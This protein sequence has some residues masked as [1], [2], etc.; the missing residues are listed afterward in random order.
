MTKH[1]KQRLSERFLLDIT[2]QEL[3]VIRRLLRSGYYILIE[4]EDANKIKVLT[5]YKGRY[6]KF[7]ATEDF[8]NI[9]TALSYNANDIHYI[10]QFVE[11][12]DK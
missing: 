4:Q 5:R 6:I 3:D 9:I 10:E 7:V 1:C 11:K 8:E 12:F 2:Y